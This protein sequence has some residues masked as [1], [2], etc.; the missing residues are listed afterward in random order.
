MWSCKRGPIMR[1]KPKSIIM[2]LPKLTCPF[3]AT[4]PLARLPICLRLRWRTHQVPFPYPRKPP[5]WPQANNIIRG[6]AAKCGVEERSDDRGPTFC[7]RR[8]PPQEPPEENASPAQRGPRREKTATA[9]FRA[10]RPLFIYCTGRTLLATHGHRSTESW[11]RPLGGAQLCA[12][13]VYSFSS[14]GCSCSSC[15]SLLYPY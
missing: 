10:Q 12:E 13:K 15:C 7:L 3:R 2:L 9:L 8:S 5:A 14:V 6:A 4:W 1:H 11:V